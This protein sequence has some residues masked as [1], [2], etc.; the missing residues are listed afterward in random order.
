MYFICLLSTG[1]KYDKDGNLNNWWSASSWNH[2][3][4]KTKCVEDYYSTYEI[5]GLK[6]NGKLTIAEN[7]ADIGGLIQS[8]HVST[9][10]QCT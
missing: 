10:K 2:F 6:V 9:L 4:N 5:L 8:Y 1:A 3:K 7:I